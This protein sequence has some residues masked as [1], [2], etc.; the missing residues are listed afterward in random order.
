[1][2]RKTPIHGDHDRDNPFQHIS[3]QRQDSQCLSGGSKDI[4]RSDILTPFFSWVDFRKES[5]EDESGGDRTQKIAEDGNKDSG[6]HEFRYI[7]SAKENQVG[8][9]S[10][11]GS[12]FM[13][14]E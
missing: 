11:S 5:G 7:I 10:A 2:I 1:M 3:N 8:M 6:G 13:E 9:G 4:G 12:K 14:L